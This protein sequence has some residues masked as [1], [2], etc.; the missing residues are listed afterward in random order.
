[1]NY[2]IYWQ[3]IQESVCKECLDGDKKGNCTLA[4]D[5]PCAIKLFLPEIVMA[6]ANSNSDSTEHFQNVTQRHVC[7]LCDW[8]LPDMSCIK[9][10]DQTCA[11]ERYRAQVAETI[12]SVMTN[13][14]RSEMNL[15]PV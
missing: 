14:E 8:Q 5:D 10:T 13:L 7:V 1:M 9:R 6:V 12:T 15:P 11:L 3:A 2:Q 4:P